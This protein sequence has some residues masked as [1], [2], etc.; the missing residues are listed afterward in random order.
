[1]DAINV[2]IVQQPSRRDLWDKFCS[3]SRF[4]FRLNASGGV[5]RIEERSG[6][7]LE[8]SSVSDFVTQTQE[9]IN[10]LRE[11]NSAMTLTIVELRAALS[12]TIPL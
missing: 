12:D 5:A 7:W 9:T 8:E 4:S 3:L 10:D 6:N 11:A 1:M 2:S